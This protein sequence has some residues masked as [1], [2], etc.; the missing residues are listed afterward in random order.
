MACPP[1]RLPG[2]RAPAN[3]PS[4]AGNGCGRRMVR[5]SPAS[6]ARRRRATALPMGQNGRRTAPAYRHSWRTRPTAGPTAEPVLVV[7]GLLGFLVPA[8]PLTHLRPG[9]PTQ[10]L[11][12]GLGGLAE[13]SELP[14]GVVFPARGNQPLPITAGQGRD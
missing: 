9:L 4:I 11:G 3:G 12:S 14:D 6:W 10:A 5:H 2:K 8:D 7:R 1:D 13:Y